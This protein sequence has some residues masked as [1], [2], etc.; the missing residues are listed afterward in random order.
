MHCEKKQTMQRC[1][2][3]QFIYKKK[4]LQSDVKRCKGG[5]R[6][7]IYRQ[8]GK[9]GWKRTCRP[10]ESPRLVDSPTA[11]P[12]PA[13]NLEPAKVKHDFPQQTEVLIER[14]ETFQLSLFPLGGN[15][16][17][18]LPTFITCQS[19]R[20]KFLCAKFCPLFYHLTLLITVFPLFFF[21]PR[22]VI[23][24]CLY[25]LSGF[26]CPGFCRV[27]SRRKDI[28]LVYYTLSNSF[29]LV[30]FLLLFL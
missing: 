6:M 21:P 4:E 25:S 30:L 13:P 3:W 19:Y 2:I 23:Y 7:A 9:T 1:N 22:D 16:I 12:G 11:N 29:L 5:G 24:Q 8:N 27:S 17:L 14:K 10:E 15:I 18:V 26:T 20:N 28:L